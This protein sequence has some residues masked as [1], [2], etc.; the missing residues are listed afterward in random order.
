MSQYPVILIPTAVEKVKSA[1]PP[2]PIFTE[3]LPQQPG[4]EP[5][6][7]N[8]TVIAVEAT[9]ATVPSVAIASQGGTVPGLLLFL[10]AVG[11][12]ATQ[13]WHQITTYP[14]RKQEHEREVANYPKKLKNYEIKKRQHEEKIKVSQSP[15]KV[16][17]FRYK[18]LMQI[19]SQTVPH[20][21]NGSRAT[22]GPAEAL[23]GNH[24]N[25]YFSGKIHQGLTLKIPDFDYPYTPDFAY[26]DKGLNLYIDIEIDEPYVYHTGAPTHFVGAW[27]DSNRNRFFLAK[28]WIVIRFSEEQVICYPQSCCKTIAQVIAQVTESNSILNQFASLTDLQPMKQWTEAEAIDMAAKKV[29][30]NYPCQNNGLHH[31]SISPMLSLIETQQQISQA[32][33]PNSRAQSRGAARAKHRALNLSNSLPANNTTLSSLVNCPYCDVKVKTAKL[34]LHRTDKCPKRPLP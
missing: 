8:T 7:L 26:I 11:A 17:D 2:E 3:P 13:A 29:R 16:A 4:A 20:D 30:D 18:L 27:K 5:E 22:R 14:Q 34:E 1:K 28:Q 15:E 25:R 24:L 23:F 33:K 21:G 31:N 6:K 9:V 12:I 10:A 19:L 32:L